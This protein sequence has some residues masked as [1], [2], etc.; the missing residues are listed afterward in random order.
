MSNEELLQEIVS[1]NLSFDL[2]VDQTIILL[3]I[4]ELIESDNFQEITL[5]GAAGTGKSTMASIIYRFCRKIGISLQLA[6]P[7]NKAAKILGQM[8]GDADAVLTIHSLLGLRPQIDIL[9]LNMRDL[10]FRQESKS[11]IPYKG[12]LIVDECSMVNDPLYDELIKSCKGQ[13][14]KI[15][16]IGDPCQLRPVKGKSISKA[17]NCKNHF[18]LIDV[19][20]QAKD[21]PLIKILTFLRENIQYKFKDIVSDQ[22]SIYCY[23]SWKVFLKKNINLFKTTIEESNC[24]FVKLLAYTNKRVEVFNSIIRILLFGNDPKEYCAGDILTAYDSITYSCST[25]SQ[26]INIENSTDYQVESAERTTKIIMG[27]VLDV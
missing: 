26:K 6:S 21:N 19:C 27:I 13:R 23:D 8:I 20:R 24:S 1:K 17:F 3:A 7:T 12:L 9:E 2:S 4:F 18:Q 16:F 22:G 14:C 15:L 11:I 10:Q 5:S 25:N